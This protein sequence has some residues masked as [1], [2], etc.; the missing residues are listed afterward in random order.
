MF[1]SSST[2]R[3]VACMPGL[4]RVPDCG[5]AAASEGVFGRKEPDAR[6]HDI[7]LAAQRHHEARRTPLEIETEFEPAAIGI[8]PLRSHRSLQLRIHLGHALERRLVRAGL[9]R[10]T[11]NAPPAPFE[12]LAPLRLKRRA[13]PPPDF[14]QPVHDARRGEIYFQRFGGTDLRPLGGPVLTTPSAAAGSLGDRDVLAVGSGAAQATVNV[15]VAVV[16]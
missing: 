4:T 15:R 7:A 5:L 8:G 11:G 13:A 1:F 14:P 2:T 12:Q 3:T 16:E 10:T 9:A 6:A